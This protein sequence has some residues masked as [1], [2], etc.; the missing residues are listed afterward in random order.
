M[1]VLRVIV[2]HYN[3]KLEKIDA[4]DPEQTINMDLSKDFKEDESKACLLK[5]IFVCI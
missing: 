3:L 4:G 5:Q 2:N 1:K